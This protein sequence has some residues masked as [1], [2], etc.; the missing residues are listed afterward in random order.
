MKMIRN[1]VL[2]T[3]LFLAQATSQTPSRPDEPQDKI[4]FATNFFMAKGGIGIINTNLYIDLKSNKN[5]IILD[6][7]KRWKG[8][9]SPTQE[10]VI[11]FQGRILPQA[12]P[13]DFDL[14]KAVVIS[15]ETDKVRFF[16]FSK[17]SGGYY[18]RP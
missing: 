13:K 8:K 1:F 16:D 9:A 6:A 10:V 14:S 11:F 2:G 17:M 7:G 4:T 15:F 18:N 3:A 12:L 5:E